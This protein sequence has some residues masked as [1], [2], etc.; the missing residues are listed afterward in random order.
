MNNRKWWIALVVVALAAAAF[1][2]RER[3]APAGSGVKP[4]AGPAQSAP[5][6]APSPATRAAAPATLQL[7]AAEV[8][9][10]APGT[11]TRGL[12]ITGTLKPVNQ[13]LVKSKVTGELRE[14]TVRE[15]MSVRAGQVVARVDPVDFQL[16]INEREAQVRSGQAQVEQSRRTVENNRQLLEKGFISQNGFDNASS[17][18]DVARAALDAA[19]A[20]LAQ[21][22]KAL[23]DTELVAP[24]AGMIAERFA[25]PGEKVSPDS[26]ILS[27]VDLSQMEIE[28]AVPSTEIGRVRVGQN[29]ELRIDGAGEKQ[30]GKVV[31]I[32]PGTQ[33]G[34]RSV[35]IYVSVANPDQRIRSGMFAQGSLAIDRRSGVLTVPL[36]AVRD[37]NGRMFVYVI[38]GDQIAER[39]V[40]LGARDESA[41]AA[42]GTA[43]AFEL[44]EGV[45]AGERIVGV[46]LGTLRAGARV[47]MIP[48]PASRP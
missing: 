2:L 14:V 5:A 21:A 13:V 15:G 38:E 9:T 40:R 26:R 22:R 36:A 7:S 1:G 19:T 18:L 12:P 3:F 28:A 25:Q 8:L 48:A 20:Q 44:L 42:D 23:A 37:A 35:L 47:E 34:T 45:R 46:N 16:R 41:L 24:I 39:D 6:G 11:I 10:I 27:I 43:G 30:I 32:N 17:G 33:A 4:G 31:R 29:V